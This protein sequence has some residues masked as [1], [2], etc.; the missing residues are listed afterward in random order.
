MTILVLKLPASRVFSKYTQSW[1]PTENGEVVRPA[2]L[3]RRPFH[4]A[5][6]NVPSNLELSTQS[7]CL[8][9]WYLRSGKQA[10]PCATNE[11]HRTPAFIKRLLFAKIW[12]RVF[13]GDF[14]LSISFHNEAVQLSAWILA[15]WLLAPLNSSR[16]TSDS[17]AKGL[18]ACPQV[19]ESITLITTTMPTEHWTKRWRWRKR[20]GRWW[21]KWTCQRRFS[22]WRRITR[23]C[24]RSVV[25]QRT[26]AT[27]YLVSEATSQRSIASRSVQS[28]P[29][30][31]AAC[32]RSDWSAQ[33]ELY[34]P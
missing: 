33:K 7:N 2:R 14:I 26:V 8:V 20:W 15:S 4:G 18:F 12:T 5:W 21:R 17:N 25:W 32:Q 27:L 19:A 31:F 11:I 28:Q 23:T 10:A 22:S 1:F 16:R 6:S 3:Y 30:R 34:N 13:N 24:S 29:K 9:N